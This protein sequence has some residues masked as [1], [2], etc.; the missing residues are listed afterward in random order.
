MS[1]KKPLSPRRTAGRVLGVAR[2]TAYFGLGVTARVGASAVNR[3]SALLGREEVT[4]TAPP[5][6][7]M[8]PA[9]VPTPGPPPAPGPAP[10]PDPGPE[11]GPMPVPGPEPVPAPDP[12][13]EA[14]AA[15]ARAASASASASDDSALEGD[16]EGDLVT[17]AG[18]PAAD[19]AVNPDTAE[20]D[21]HQQD[22][23][24]LLDASTVKS[25]T[26]ESDVLR[27]AADAGRG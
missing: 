10:A 19:P 23:P 21:F 11:P 16:L 9:P 1:S 5:V 3:A 26:H 22:T 4:V 2:D 20:A 18:I 14:L 27:R 13:G 17:P 12:V 24:P 7:P 6:E 8:P 15:E 25:V